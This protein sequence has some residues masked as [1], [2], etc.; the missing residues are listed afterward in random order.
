MSEVGE[1]E[2]A[3]EV[4]PLRQAL[5]EVQRTEEERAGRL[6][7]LLLLLLLLPAFLP[8]WWG[9]QA[10]EEAGDGDDV[11]LLSLTQDE[12]V[13][14]DDDAERIERILLLV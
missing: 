12:G 10:D 14:G 6:P 3:A 2:A 4:Q 11:L 1:E 13:V 7:Y 8:S 5:C 9:S